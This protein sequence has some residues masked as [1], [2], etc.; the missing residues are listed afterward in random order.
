MEE[1]P[2][3][4]GNLRASLIE[5]GISLIMSE[6]IEHLSLRRVA[7]LCGVSQA[8]PYAHFQNKDAL[9][10]AM[11]D[12]VTQ[13]FAEA[14]E[15]AAQLV[16]DENSP[17]LLVEMGKQYV[18]FFLENPHYFNFIFSQEW[19]QVDLDLNG[20]EQ[21]NFPPY[22]LLKMHGQRILQQTGMTN[23]EIEDSLISM[24]AT[25][26]GLTSIATMGNVHYSKRWVDKIEDIL[27]IQSK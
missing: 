13:R 21:A 25:V 9:L 8:A 22:Q 12:Y 26:H 3:H 14:L 17:Q 11:R 7:S 27:T 19:M 5:A 24:W 6:G 20:T 2:Y 4:H 10:N 18:L 15:V 23:Q 16:P 1:K